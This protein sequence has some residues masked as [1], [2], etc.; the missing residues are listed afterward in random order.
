MGAPIFADAIIGAFPQIQQYLMVTK[1]STETT[2]ALPARR[3]FNVDEYF[4]MEE[5]GI[6]TRGDGIELIDG[7]LFCKYDGR[8]RRFTV[9]EYYAM[10]EAG[11]LPPGERTELLAGEIFIMTAVGNRHVF[12]LRWL[13][14][15]MMF[16]VGDSAVLDV[17]SPVT[18]NTGSEPEPDFMILRWRD[19]RYRESPKP[20]PEDV[21]LVIEVSDTTAG[22]DRRH[23][24]PLYAAQGIPEMWLFDVNARHVEVYDQPIAGGYARMRVVGPDE[25]LSPAA[26][27][28]V[29]ISVAEVM[30]D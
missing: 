5:A 18:L 2:T 8:R 3:L 10:T 26:L 7:Q 17:Q 16:A 22:F 9:K 25:T 15:A 4:A 12:C 28:D 6:L 1:M 21:L 14:K 23:K 11:I 27:P 24:A 19:D 30:P 13:N 29:V 20:G